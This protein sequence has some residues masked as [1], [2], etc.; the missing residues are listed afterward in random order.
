MKKS[1]V[2]LALLSVG[3]VQAQ[4]LVVK[5]GSSAPLT[6]A[7]AHLGKDTENG[8]RLAIE[9]YNKKGVTIGGKK[10]KFELVGED[11]Q[12]DPKQG[13]AVAQ[14]LVDAG[15]KAVIGHMNSGTTIPASR[16][17]NQ[18]GVVMISPS[19]T[20]PTLTQQG[21]EN[22]FRVM[23]HDGKQGPAAAKFALTKLGKKVAVIDDRSAYGQGLADEFEKAVK[24]G[25]G[26]ITSREFTTD[27]ANDFMTILTKVKSASPDVIFF[28]GMDPQGGPMAKQI[29]QLG[30]KATFLMGD[31]GCTPE[32]IKLAGD[33]ITEGSAYCTQPGV[34]LDS[35]P[36]AKFKD[37]FKARFNAEVQAYSPYSYDATSTVIEA[38]KTAGSVEPAKYLASLKKASHKGV[39][40]VIKFD[41]KGDLKDGVVTVYTFKAG[42]WVPL[43]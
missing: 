28:G 12:A 24:A 20:N 26:S 22:V 14:R 9:D 17:Y 7:Q 39:S 43:K 21:F 1:I 32:L 30:I 18:A 27:K 34:P 11:D 3:V 37:R 23:A 15:V 10:V 25:G 33:A 42:K 4:E 29:K 19:A 41:E 5:I 16:I 31:G 36:D 40:G 6:G 35:M 38:M 2:A 8:V 13:T